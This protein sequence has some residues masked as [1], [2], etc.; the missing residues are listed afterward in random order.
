[1]AGRQN[2][3]IAEPEAMLLENE[4]ALRKARRLVQFIRDIEE[5]ER[6][7]SARPEQHSVKAPWTSPRPTESKSI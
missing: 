3:P 7:I 1:M 2:P 4:I 5:Y 6:L